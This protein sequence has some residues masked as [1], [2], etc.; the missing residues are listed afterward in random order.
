MAE[1]DNKPKRRIVKKADS[2]REATEKNTNAQPKKRGV[3][4][5][6]LHYISVPFRIIGRPF[7]RL[8]KLKPFRIM[9]YILW[10]TYFRNSFKELRQVTW[11]S[12][13]ESFQLTGAVLV[14][15]SIFGI[16]IALVDYGLDKLFK[17]VLLK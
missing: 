2:V 4:R 7:K 12:R 17:Q 13:R 6:S 15:A 11:P 9:G 8:G 3:V 10:P 16:A 1:A 14:F 5:L